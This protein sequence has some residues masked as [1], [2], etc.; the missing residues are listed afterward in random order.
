M[1][2]VSLTFV[3]VCLTDM[4]TTCGVVASDYLFLLVAIIFSILVAY[5][6]GDLLLQRKSLET[7]FFFLLIFEGFIES[8]IRLCTYVIH[9]YVMACPYR[10]MTA[11][12]NSGI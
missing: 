6:D 11:D 5:A 3:R 2:N 10:N 1:L 8:N 9:R 12:E 7:P 4:V